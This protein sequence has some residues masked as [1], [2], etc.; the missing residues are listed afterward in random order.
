MASLC[1][2]GYPFFISP[3]WAADVEH[4]GSSCFKSIGIGGSLLALPTGIHT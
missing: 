2:H 4:D 3:H 1:P